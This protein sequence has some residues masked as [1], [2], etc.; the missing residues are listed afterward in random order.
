LVKDYYRVPVDLLS[1]FGEW[2]VVVY[3]SSLA[4]GEIM[5]DNRRGGDD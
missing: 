2:Y 3:A 1:T 4:N 5:D